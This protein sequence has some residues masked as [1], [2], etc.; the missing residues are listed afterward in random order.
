M[1]VKLWG[2]GGKRNQEASPR[3]GESTAT[4]PSGTRVSR[5]DDL[6]I[7]I[8]E[9]DLKKNLREPGGARKTSVEW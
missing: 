4:W 7:I 5:T 8:K 6:P 3:R 9:R 1:K 2:G